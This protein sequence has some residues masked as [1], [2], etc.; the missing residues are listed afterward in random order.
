[1][2]T[3]IPS[4]FRK[5]HSQKQRKKPVPPPPGAALTLVAGSY[6]S[7]ALTLDIQFDRAVNA[8][9]MQFA[10]MTLQDGIYNHLDYVPNSVANTGPSSLRFTLYPTGPTEAGI[11]NL[12]AT[13][14][15]GIVAIND[16]GIWPG[17]D[18]LEL[19]WP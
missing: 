13:A 2:I 18:G 14:L 4:Q 7:D 6:D 10:Q 5:S 16:G 3:P 12:L 9:G 19:P 17:T 8:A 1:M 11:V 15:T